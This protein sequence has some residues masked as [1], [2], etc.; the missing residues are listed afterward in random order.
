MPELFTYLFRHIEC[1]DEARDRIV[2]NF[3]IGARQ[4][5]QGLVGLLDSFPGR[6]IV[7]GSLP[8]RR[9]SFLQLPLPATSPFNSTLPSPFRG[10]NLKRWANAHRH[11]ILRSTVES[12]KDHV[13]GGK[14]GSLEAKCSNNADARPRL[15]LNS[16]NQSDS[17]YAALPKNLLLPP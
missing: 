13:A 17:L 8:K 6:R 5:F 9:P 1:F 2:R 3:F 10:A 14:Q 11:P 16:Q 7:P 12:S 15:P 4:L